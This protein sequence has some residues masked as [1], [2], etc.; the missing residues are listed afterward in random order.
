MGDN[1]LAS[2]NARSQRRGSRA[3]NGL[4]LPGNF[5]HSQRGRFRT[6]PSNSARLTCSQGQFRFSDSPSRPNAPLHPRALLLANSFRQPREFLFREASNPAAASADPDL[7][8]RPPVHFA[9]KA[10]HPSQVAQEL[11]AR[12][13]EKAQYLT[14]RQRLGGHAGVGLY[15]PAHAFAPPGSQPMAASRIPHESNRSEQ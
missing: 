1:P 10:V 3:K 6:L 14:H 7:G 4:A 9:V 13:P 8:L 5:L 2:S 12:D 11:P 15:P